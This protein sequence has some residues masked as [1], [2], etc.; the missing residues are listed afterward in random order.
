MGCTL[1]GLWR[2]STI[3]PKL[4]VDLF[5][6]KSMQEQGQLAQWAL[7]TGAALAIA[8]WLVLGG[9]GVDRIFRWAQYAGTR[10]DL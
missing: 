2:L 6:V 8:I 1:I 7:Y 9:K 3:V 5:F 4:A 10:K